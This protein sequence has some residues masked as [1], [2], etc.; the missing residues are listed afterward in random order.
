MDKKS[1]NKKVLEYSE[2]KES[3]NKSLE[4]IKLRSCQQHTTSNVLR[5]ENEVKSEIEATTNSPISCLERDVFGYYIF[6][7]LV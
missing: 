1:L 2:T 4:S 7:Q 5:N 3:F 6:S